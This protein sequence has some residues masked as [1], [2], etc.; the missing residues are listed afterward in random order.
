M[1]LDAYMRAETLSRR[2]LFR[3]CAH[4]G[5]QVGLCAWAARGF[6]S[7]YASSPKAESETVYTFAVPRFKLRLSVEFFD[8]YSSDGFWFKDRTSNRSFCVAMNGDENRSC[9]SN[10]VGSIAVAHYHLEPRPTKPQPF[11]LREHVRTIDEDYRVTQRPPFDRAIEFQNGMASDIQ[12]FGYES[13]SAPPA[14]KALPNPW[15]LV[16]QD[17]YLENESSAA[18]VMHWKQSLRSIRLLDVI[19]GDNTRVISQPGIERKSG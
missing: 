8:N 19:P 1:N 2:R 13:G 3:S 17:L 15:C 16:R 9:L 12:A 4:S 5:Q 11:R 14:D 10:F 6:V 7:L 18:L